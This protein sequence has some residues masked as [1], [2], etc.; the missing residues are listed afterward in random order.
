MKRVKCFP[1]VPALSLPAKGWVAGVHLWLEGQCLWGLTS[2]SYA[3]LASSLQLS[4]HTPSSAHCAVQCSPS[5]AGGGRRNEAVV[6]EWAE[7]SAG[8]LQEWID[9][10]LSWNPEEYGGI[11]AIRVP[12]ESLWL[13]DIVLFEK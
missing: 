7:D 6:Y 8:F 12:S 9:H 2:P 1:G 13:P 10:K 4:R 3:C 11:T 5:E